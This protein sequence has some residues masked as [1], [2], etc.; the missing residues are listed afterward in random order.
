[1]PDSKTEKTREE[2]LLGFAKKLALAVAVVVAIPFLLGSLAAPAGGFYVGSQYN[3]D[4]HMVYAAWMRQAMEGRFF[5][6]NRFAVDAQPGLTVQL[7]FWA[8]GLVAKLVG[9]VGAANLARIGLS[10]YFVMLLAKLL[11]RLDFSIFTAKLAIFMASFGAGFGWLAW[12]RFGVALSEQKP[13]L[14]RLVMRGRAPIDVWQPEAFVMP[15]MLTNGL[16]MASLCL[17][18]GVLGAAVRAKDDWRAVPAGAILFGLLM[19]VHSYDVLLLTF[20][21]VGFGI[22]LVASK[23]ATWA[24]AARVGVIGLGAIPAAAWFVHVLQN[25]PV[26][27]AR[28]ATETFAPHF[29]AVAFGLAPAWVLA[30]VA[31]VRARDLAWRRWAALGLLAILG[32]GLYA[33][34]WSHDPNGYFLGWGAWGLW[35]AV[36]L[37]VLALLARKSLGWNLFWAWGVVG[38]CA[39]YWPML[40][41]RKLAMGL[42]VP[43]AILGAVG[44]ARI[45]KPLDRAPRN[46]VAS[47]ALLVLCA[48]SILW[49]Q[50]EITF[51]RENVSNTTVHRLLYGPEDK[52]LIDGLAA[53]PGRKVLVAMPGIPIQDPETKEFGTPYLPDMNPIFTAFAG[54]FSYAGH[55]SETPHYSQRRGEV[56]RFFFEWTPEQ[57]SQWLAKIGA[58]H[59]LAPI[60]AAFPQLSL[61]ELPHLGSEIDQ[62]DHYRLF[63][64]SATRSSD[65]SSASP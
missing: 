63:A 17:M 9:I 11:L 24:W 60:P 32:V 52:R 12:E 23:Q 13:E 2:E 27:Q 37:V 29:A 3:V 22:T 33:L 65:S 38:V 39:P 14:L 59:V 25:D 42:M 53:R 64:V 49:L 34:A 43:W 31:L 15:S 35:F 5:F 41:Q 58:T 46:L 45:L 54:V 20:V 62:S 30:T 61:R 28:A 19:N 26:F 50:R 47:L 16:F 55:W 48:G 36:V 51:V 18:L 7:Y 4:D 40:F 8:L 21:M 1:M 10:A 56:E 6:E 44:L 57:Q